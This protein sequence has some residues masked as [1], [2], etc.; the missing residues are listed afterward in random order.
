MCNIYIY[1]LEV[2]GQD[3]ADEHIFKSKCF[4]FL[5]SFFSLVSIS[6]VCHNKP[7]DFSAHYYHAW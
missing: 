7:P 1:I 6:P 5:F 4:T 3:A 2:I